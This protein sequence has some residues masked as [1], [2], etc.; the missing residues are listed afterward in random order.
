MNRIEFN[1]NSVDYISISSRIEILGAEIR[2]KLIEL[3]ANSTR[4]DRIGLYSSESIRIQAKIDPIGFGAMSD[5][6]IIW[7]LITLSNSTNS[8]RLDPKTR[9]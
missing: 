2:F 8:Y 1:Q 3:A 5:R 4:T 7:Q 9:F 6:T